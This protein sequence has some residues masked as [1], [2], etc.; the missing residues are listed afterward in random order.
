MQG[1]DAN[2][3]TAAAIVIAIV[4]GGRPLLLGQPLQDRCAG[5]R[6]SC[7]GSSAAARWSAA[8]L[9]GQPL[10]AAVT[11]VP[12]AGVA[13]VAGVGLFVLAGAT[14]AALGLLADISERF[15]ADRGAIMGLYSVFLAIGQIA[16]SLIGGFAAEWRG[17]DGMLL[18]TIVLL[19]V[20]LLPLDRLRGPGAPD[21]WHDAR[22]ARRRGSAARRSERDRRPAVGAGP[23]RAGQPRRRRRAAPPRDERP[24]S[25]ILR[26]GGSAVD[27]AIATNAVLAVV[28]PSS[29]GIGGDA[30]WLI[31]DAADRTP[32]RAQRLGPGAGGRRRARRS[33]RGPRPRIPL[34]GPLAITVP[35]AVRS[36]GDAHA[37]VRAAAARDAPRPGDRAGPG[38][39]PRVGTASST[40]SSG[41]RRWSP[42][43]SG[44]TPFFAVYRPCGR[45]WQP[46]RAGAAAGACR[47]ARDARATR[48]SRR[49]TRVTSPSGRP[50]RWLRPDRPITSDRP[51][52]PTR[53][54]WG[55][56]IGIDYRGVRVTTHPP[57][58][59]GIVA[60]ELL[61]ILASSSRL[62][63]RRSARTGSPTRA[64]ST[65][66]SRRRSWRWPTATRT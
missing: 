3:I 58:S 37:P 52:R 59:S 56:P 50:G 63:R 41:R 40:R 43:H 29:C 7:T 53:S 38:R 18:A 32:G 4:F 31:W 62:R 28:M 2:Q 26:A 20:A 33:A 60:L 23:A 22:G 27:A 42:T 47:H 12:I 15:P 64:G 49:S 48:A 66:G 16:G 35:G 8:G 14:P 45:P 65:S 11:V 55:E 46:G 6:S 44:P 21:R 19:V 51:A 54:T 39:L 30:F 34:R 57:N 10:G 25:A 1:F 9:R 5:R 36:W 24:G 13:V 17:I 61:A